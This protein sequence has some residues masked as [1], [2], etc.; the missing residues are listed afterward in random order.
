MSDLLMNPALQEEVQAGFG[1]RRD[2]V[3]KQN[4]GKASF[5]GPCRVSKIQK[6]NDGSHCKICFTIARQF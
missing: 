6:I 2:L 1:R 3:L 5:W 4:G